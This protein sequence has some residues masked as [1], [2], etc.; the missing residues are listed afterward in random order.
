MKPCRADDHI[1]GQG[2]GDEWRRWSRAEAGGGT[3]GGG[4]GAAPPCAARSRPDGAISRRVLG[5]HQGQR[6]GHRYCQV[7]RH[8]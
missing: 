1:D 5:P 3:A 6:V 2:H 7:H 4:G 8:E